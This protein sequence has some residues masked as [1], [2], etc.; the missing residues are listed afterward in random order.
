MGGRSTSIIVTRT[1][2]GA[3]VDVW[4]NGQSPTRSLKVQ[5]AEVS[6]FESAMKSVFPAFS[7]PPVHE[8]SGPWKVDGETHPEALEWDFWRKFERP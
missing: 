5:R 3:D 7:M 8:D 4:L 1:P 2:E 6:A